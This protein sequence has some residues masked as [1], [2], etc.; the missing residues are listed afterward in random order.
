M[1][2]LVKPS[3]VGFI[4]LTTAIDTVVFWT[5]N[6]R[7]YLALDGELW[8]IPGDNSVENRPCFK[9]TALYHRLGRENEQLFHNVNIE[10]WIRDKISCPMA[11]N[12][13][14]WCRPCSSQADPEQNG[15]HFQMYFLMMTSSDGNIFRVT[16]H[17]CGEFTGHR[18]ILRTEASDAE[19]WCFLWYT[20]E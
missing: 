4:S 9:R 16:G 2:R 13:V 18:W 8:G 7:Q 5:F 20:P 14:Y 15:R 11:H 19:L 1:V 6:R 3:A 10:P 12:T 17:L